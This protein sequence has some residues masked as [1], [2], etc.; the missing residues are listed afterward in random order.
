[1]SASLLSHCPTPVHLSLFNGHVNLLGVWFRTL[2]IQK[3]WAEAWDSYIFNRLSGDASIPDPW[4]TPG[5]AKL[6]DWITLPS[7]CQSI[8]TFLE[9][10]PLGSASR[11]IPKLWDLTHD[12][13]KW[14]WCN[15]NN[16][17]NC[18][19]NG[20]MY[21]NHPE[22]VPPNPQS[23]EKLFSMKQVPGDVLGTAALSEVGGPAELS[24]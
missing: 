12:G 15:N 17:T 4:A 2:L 1:M 7:T 24:G 3:V 9:A 23:M 5:I 18:I 14:S 13:S 21:L 10:C 16:I 19:T 6:Y 22:I 20:P 11:R 8:N